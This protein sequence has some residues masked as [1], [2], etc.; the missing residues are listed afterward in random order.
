MKSSK[1]TRFFFI[2]IP[3]LLVDGVALG[4]HPRYH[5]ASSKTYMPQECKK[6]I[7]LSAVSMTHTATHL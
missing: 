1:F 6:E 4:G 7:L 2:T 3:K 5:S